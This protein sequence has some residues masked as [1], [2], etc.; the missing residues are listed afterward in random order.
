VISLSCARGPRSFSLA[1][2]AIPV[3]Q[4]KMKRTRGLILVVG[5]AT[6]GVRVGRRVAVVHR[7]PERRSIVTAAVVRASRARCAR[8]R[9]VT[10]ERQSLPPWIVAARVAAT[11]Q[12]GRHARCDSMRGSSR[13]NG[14]PTRFATEPS[15]ASR[16]HA[17]RDARLGA[18]G[19]DAR[20][21]AAVDR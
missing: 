13:S 3:A 12:L 17:L 9:A 20:L 14:T 8:R 19:D 10:R 1:I 6:R 16:P 15:G 4:A 11:V 5:A 7:R 2:V 21:P 18:R